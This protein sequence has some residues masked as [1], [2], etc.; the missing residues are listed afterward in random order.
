MGDNLENVSK[1]AKIAALEAKV[2][3]LLALPA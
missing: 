2:A 3:I 1:D